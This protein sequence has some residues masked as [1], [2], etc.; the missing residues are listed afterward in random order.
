VPLRHGGGDG[1]ITL[2]FVRLRAREPV[3]P[4][5]ALVYLAGGPGES[6]IDD[7]GWW[8]V[9]DLLAARAERV[10]VIAFDQRGA[11]ASRP[12]LVVSDRWR[13]PAD[14]AG[15]D[16]QDAA[17]IAATLT[18]AR[19]SQG[20]RGVDL[21]AYTTEQS[22][23]DVAFVAAALGY[24]RID[25]IGSSYGSHLGLTVIRRHPRMVQRAVLALVEGPDH[26]WKLPRAADRLF[27]RLAGRGD[28]DARA[29]LRRVLDRLD[30]G[31][32]VDGPGGRLVL[33]R[34]DLQRALAGWLGDTGFLWRLDEHL[35]ALDR[36]DL[37]WLVARTREARDHDVGNLMSWAMDAASGA[38]GRRRDQIAADAGDA[39]LGDALNWPLRACPDGFVEDLGPGFRA[40]VGSDVPVLLISGELDVRTPVDNALEV[41]ATLPAAGRMVL[42]DA[43]H[44]YG[45]PGIPAARDAAIRW[46]DGDDPVPERIERDAHLDR[47]V[48]A[49]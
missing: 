41:A 2:A 37:G 5:R 4:G 29:T 39:V 45:W 43:A 23:D 49:S 35:G 18:E 25:L 6:G 13:L 1:A 47:V 46:F 31:V 17:S 36:G 3:D 19:A 15:D 32:A 21:R 10:D 34:R 11:G 14:R 7:A 27:E 38:S 9:H 44:L 26:T 22:A 24:E 28:L 8:P 30:P 48:A 42:D 40:P 20:E 33:G 12:S 16:E